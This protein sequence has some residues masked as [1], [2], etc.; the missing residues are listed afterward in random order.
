MKLQTTTK[1][2]NLMNQNQ[3]QPVKSLIFM[4]ALCL[5]VGL[6]QSCNIEKPKNTPRQNDFIK[7][8]EQKTLEVLS[9][10]LNTTENCIIRDSTQ[11]F[12]SVGDILKL[13]RFKGKVVYLDFWGTRCKPCL[14]EF[15]YI[16]DLKKK[17]QNQP[18]EYLYICT[19]GSKEGYKYKDMLWTML[20]KKYK[21]TGINVLV[22]EDAKL[23]FYERYKNIVDP[24]W[25]KV[26]PVYLLFNKQ[27]QVVEFNAP[28]P[29]S[30]EVLYKRIQELLDE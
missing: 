1:N 2:R 11:V 6:I 13:E 25:S 7:S 17:F 9:K 3:C 15:A 10:Q 8:Q 5:T 12:K 21:L 22:S 19:Y 29:S 20:I 27:G 14:E 30:K 16:P 28:R 26:V 4:Y 24:G 23:R 18:I